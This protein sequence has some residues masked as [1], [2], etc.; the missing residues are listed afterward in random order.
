MH[1]SESPGEHLTPK[2]PFN[3]KNQLRR[4]LFNL[5]I[6]ILLVAAPTGIAMSYVPSVSRVAIFMVNF[7]AIVPLAAILSFAT[8][9]IALRTGE[10]LGGLLNA[11]FGYA[12]SQ[13]VVGCSACRR[14]QAAL[15]CRG[16][17][18]G[19]ATCADAG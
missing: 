2:D 1:D 8:E 14:C 6:N 18:G 16:S 15:S 9:E 19:G 5:W 13:N 3:I 7:L 12:R 11:T 17:L 4:T 10:T